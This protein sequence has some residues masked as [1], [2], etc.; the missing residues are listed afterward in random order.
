MTELKK[1]IAMIAV[2]IVLTLGVYALVRTAID[3]Q[4]YWGRSLVGEGVA[5]DEFWA[6]MEDRK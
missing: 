3:P 5:Q 4:W 6:V 2:A 1:K